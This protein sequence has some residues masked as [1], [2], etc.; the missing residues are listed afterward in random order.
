MQFVNNELDALILKAKPIDFN[1]VWAT[2]WGSMDLAC[3]GQFA[4]QLQFGEVRYFTYT[5]FS[6]D[7]VERKGVLIGL[8]G[9]NVVIYENYF[10]PSGVINISVTASDKERYFNDLN[11]EGN[12]ALKMYGQWPLLS[13]VIS[14]LGVLMPVW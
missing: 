11:L 6:I 2:R 1:P 12:L 4:P 5:N 13:E 10:L 3:K 8:N 9:S 7:G 14:R